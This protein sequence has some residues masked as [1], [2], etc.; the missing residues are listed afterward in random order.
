M[1]LG[2]TEQLAL[3][4]KRQWRIE[5]R[6]EINWWPRGD[7]IIEQNARDAL[8]T[9]TQPLNRPRREWIGRQPADPR[10]LWRVHLRDRKRP[11]RSHSP[12]RRRNRRLNRESAKNLRTSSYRVNRYAPVPSS[13]TTR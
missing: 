9:R 5:P 6:N 10:V 1:R 13:N 12:A 3:G 11:R 2:N 4:G 7:E 8:D